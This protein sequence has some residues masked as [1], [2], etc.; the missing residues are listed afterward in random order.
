MLKF[1]HVALAICLAGFPLI[2]SAQSVTASD[3][4]AGTWSGRIGQGV[5]PN[6]PVTLEL[7]RDGAAVTGTLVGADQRGEMRRGSYDAATG[8]LTLEFIAASGAAPLTL[9]GTAVEGTAVGRV[10]VGGSTGTFILSRANASAAAD[11]ANATVP[12]AGLR[13]AY[14]EVIGNVAKAAAMVPD[15]KYA[16]QPASTVR[17]F[18]QVI[19]HIVDA[20]QYYCS[21]AGRRNIEW[22]DANA[23]GRADKTTLL[24]RLQEATALCESAHAQGDAGPLIINLAHTNLH[25]GNLVTYLRLLGLVPPSSN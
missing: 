16:F 20:S 1:R 9:D 17:T 8:A 6:Y 18:G 7:K 4:I 11:A 14:A 23:L 25:Y 12:R 10:L 19:G 21:R 13:G 15:D 3:P 2:A 22:S 24:P 5:N